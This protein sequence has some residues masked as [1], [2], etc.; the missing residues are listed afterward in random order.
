[1]RKSLVRQLPTFPVE[2]P[3]QALQ[4]KR[5]PLPSL[6]HLAPC[7][8]QRAFLLHDPHT[9][10]TITG[11][12]G[13]GP[14]LLGDVLLPEGVFAQLQGAGDYQQLLHVLFPAIRK[15]GEARC[16]YACACAL[17]AGRQALRHAAKLSL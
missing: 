11:S 10:A 14:H 4:L 17:R 7:W 2:R 1:M 15:V 9:G 8:Q 13:P 5:I 12:P 16:A 3:R 6:E